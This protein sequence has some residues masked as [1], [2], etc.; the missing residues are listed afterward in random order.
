MN[1]SDRA[2]FLLTRRSEM[3]VNSAPYSIR[4]GGGCDKPSAD[5]VAQGY[6][7]EGLLFLS[8]NRPGQCGVAGQTE[9]TN[10]MRPPSGAALA[11]TRDIPL[12][13]GDDALQIVGDLVAV[14]TV[15]I[16]RGWPVENCCCCG[17]WS[18]SCGECIIAIVTDYLS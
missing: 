9:L 16:R 15:V 10:D 13:K 14:A 17:G 6:L 5:A 2:L 3:H 1:R 7:D 8:S 4:G 18:L 12:K 11:I